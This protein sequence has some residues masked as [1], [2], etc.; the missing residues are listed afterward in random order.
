[1]VKELKRILNINWEDEETDLKLQEII[2][3]GK[4]KINTLLGVD[5]NY[6]LNQEAKSLLLNFARYD[7][8]NASEY[9]EENFQKEILRLQY[10]EACKGL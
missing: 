8:N 9:F 6:E 7:F 5:V 4:S 3:R 1:M 2:E 10:I